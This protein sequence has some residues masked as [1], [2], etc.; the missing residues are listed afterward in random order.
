MDV[1]PLTFLNPVLADAR[2][3]PC[4]SSMIEDLGRWRRSV[5]QVYFHGMPLI[6]ADHFTIIAE[7]EPLLV[8]GFDDLFES[9]EIEF[10]TMPVNRRDQF[11]NIHPTIFR[12]SDADNFRLMSQHQ[13][14]KPAD[15]GGLLRIHGVVKAWMTLIGPKMWRL[16]SPSSSAGTQS[17]W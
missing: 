2:K 7:G 17:S 8:I 14:E 6:G 10:L 1:M 4:Y 11:I 5:S 16:N 3:K 12:E 15:L 9:L 13:A